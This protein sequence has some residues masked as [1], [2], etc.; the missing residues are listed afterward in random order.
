MGHDIVVQL[1]EILGLERTV[2]DL[3]DMLGIDGRETNGQYIDGWGFNTLK[4]SKMKYAPGQ[5]SKAERAYS[6]A[7]VG[8]TQPGGGIGV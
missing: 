1:R 2:V 3:P 8:I 6:P 4:M 5:I 7:Q